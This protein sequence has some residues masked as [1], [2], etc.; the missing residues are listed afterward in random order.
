MKHY[1][2]AFKEYF[3]VIDR[4]IKYTTQTDVPF[5]LINVTIIFFY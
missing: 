2:L 5:K 3:Y 4:I 1:L